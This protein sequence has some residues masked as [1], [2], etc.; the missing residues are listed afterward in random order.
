[1]NDVFEILSEVVL[2]LEFERNFNTV[3]HN[4]AQQGL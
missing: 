4:S 2:N 1:M 3:Y